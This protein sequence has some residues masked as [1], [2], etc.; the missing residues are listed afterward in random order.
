MDL[1]VG[2]P[3]IPDPALRLPG[4]RKYR[5]SERLVLAL[6]AESSERIAARELLVTLAERFWLRV[7]GELAVFALGCMNSLIFTRLGSRWSCLKIESTSSR[8][9][10]NW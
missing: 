2:G 1:S 8:A 9:N 5:R 4:V 3:V 6:G 7:F 10:F